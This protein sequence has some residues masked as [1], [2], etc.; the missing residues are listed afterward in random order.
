MPKVK[1]K[2]DRFVDLGPFEIAKVVNHRV[3][4][5]DNRWVTT[6]RCRWKNYEPC[7]DTWERLENLNDCPRLL[8]DYFVAK[9]K[10]YLAYHEKH[11]LP[12]PK[13]RIR[14]PN[15]A[16]LQFFSLKNDLWYIPDGSELVKRILTADEIGCQKYLTVVFKHLKPDVVHVPQCLLEYYFPFETVV[17]Y[18][19]KQL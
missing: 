1:G 15:K 17:L 13:G 14:P 12:P 2:I 8:A 10:K 9:Y 19:R 4:K 3:E 16:C 18:N 6:F 11:N 5:R 7:D